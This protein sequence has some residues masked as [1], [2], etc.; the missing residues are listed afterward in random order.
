VPHGNARKPDAF[1]RPRLVE[2]DFPT[3]IN[4]L[5]SRPGPVSD[6]VLEV[7]E[8]ELGVMGHGLS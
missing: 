3:L 8:Q 1:Y 4:Q 5:S 2:A 6:A 7:I